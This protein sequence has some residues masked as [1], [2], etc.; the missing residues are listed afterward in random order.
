MSRRE[1]GISTVSYAILL[2][3]FLLLIFGSYEIWKLVAVKQSL[4]RAT[5]LATRALGRN[6]PD[7]THRDLWIQSQRE[8]LLGLTTKDPF[9][10]RQFARYG[11]VG[12]FL[13]VS[14]DIDAV[15]NLPADDDSKLFEVHA[16][17]QLPWLVHIPLLGDR[18]FTLS[19]RHIGGF[20]H[21]RF[22]RDM[23]GVQPPDPETQGWF[24]SPWPTST[25][26]P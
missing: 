14:V 3:I 19:A 20:T 26:T 18:Y 12:R 25:S 2:P 21:R 17:L 23:R 24:V 13:R 15:P 16:E 11:G 8:I 10:E 7:K 9:V 4:N 1:L 22:G 5:Y 6:L